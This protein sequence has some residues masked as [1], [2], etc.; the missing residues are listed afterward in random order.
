VYKTPYRDAVSITPS[1]ST[2]IPVPRA[3]YVG[4][5]GHLEVVMYGGTT[6]IFKSVPA[7]TTLEI[8]VTKIKATNTTATLILALY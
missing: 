4:G 2:I 8:Y 5:A 3:V 1:D 7:G 6:V